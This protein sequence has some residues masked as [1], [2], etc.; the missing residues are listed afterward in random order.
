MIE[1]GRVCVKLAGRDAGKKAVIIDAL[2]DHY[3]MIDG[4]TRRRKCNISHIELLEET[5][6]V[7]K[8]ATTEEVCKA[9]NIEFKKKVTKEKK[10][11]PKKQKINKKLLREKEEPK[12]K[13]KKVAK[14]NES[15]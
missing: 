13:V 4:E 14:K 12:K 5:V 15:K 8:N 6:E 11:R 9:L 1:V 10:E 2:D 3:V 7:K